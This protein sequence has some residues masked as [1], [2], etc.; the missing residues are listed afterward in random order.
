MAA[1]SNCGSESDVKTGI[2]ISIVSSFSFRSESGRSV[3]PSTRSFMRIRAKKKDFLRASPT[4]QYSCEL[5]SI[6]QIDGKP[7]RRAPEEIRP[8]DYRNAVAKKII[9]ETKPRKGL[10]IFHAK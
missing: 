10:T 6:A 2:S 7:I 8:F 1:R 4:T 5:D 3:G 9:V